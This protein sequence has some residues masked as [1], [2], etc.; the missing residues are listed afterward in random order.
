MLGLIGSTSC[1][2]LLIYW[3]GEEGVPNSSFKWW[4]VISLALA[5]F[6]LYTVPL[7][8]DSDSL[9]GLWIEAKKDKLRK[10]IDELRR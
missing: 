3:L 7:S 1:L 9:V 6:H 5:A 4:A 8:Q 10:Q 2:I